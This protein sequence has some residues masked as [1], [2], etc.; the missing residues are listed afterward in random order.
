VIAYLAA[1]G[2]VL[3]TLGAASPPSSLCAPASLVHITVSN[4]S[5]GLDPASFAAKP[6][7]YYRIGSDRLRIEEA[8]DTADGIHALIV[9]A[10]PNVWLANLYNGT[11]K[12]VVD[13]G[14]TFVAR[15]PLFGTTLGGKFTGLEFGCENDFIAANGLKVVRSEQI[16]A[17]V[18]DVYRIENESDAIEIL[19]HSGSG[20]PAYA[21]YYHQGQLQIAIQYELYATGLPND[22]ALFSPPPNVR[23]TDVRR[24]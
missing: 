8:T 1:L 15:A 16:G 13:P 18:F 11:G 3:A 2:S 17:S 4:V 6:K 22:P 24:Q 20:T 23:Y 21:R 14:P 10:E 7:E 12:H 5:P 19:E 9:V